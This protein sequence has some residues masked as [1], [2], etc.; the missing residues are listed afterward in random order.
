MG[1][2]NSSRPTIVSLP[3][4]PLG[5]QPPFDADGLERFLS[6]PRIATVS[7]VRASG[8]PNQTPLWFDYSDGEMRFVVS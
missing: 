7:Y 3:F 8:R 1:T 5:G 6:E 4:R 2:R